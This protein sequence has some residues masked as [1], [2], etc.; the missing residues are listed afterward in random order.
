MNI[1]ALIPARMGSSRFPGKPLADIHGMAMLGHVWN[2]AK[3]SPVLDEVFV[4]TCDQEIMD[5][6]ERLGGKGIMTLDTHERCTE[7]TSEALHKIEDLLQEKVDIIVMLQG[8]EPMIV[9]E[10]INEAV[11]P[12][13]KDENIPVVNLM[14]KMDTQEEHEDPNEVKVVTDLR[15]N[16]I[17]F[18]REAIPSR[19]KFNGTIPMMKQVCVIPFRRDFLIEFNELEPTPLEVVESVDMMRVLEHGHRVKMVETNFSSY[20]VDTQTDLDKVRVMMKTDE[21]V[22]SYQR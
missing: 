13:L 15:G 10:M 7:R 8:D 16:A 19:K 22:A 17:Y 5:Y 2:R 3:L 21:L 20:S 6:I 14:A 12:M 4:A 9:P 11:A 18:S 1:L